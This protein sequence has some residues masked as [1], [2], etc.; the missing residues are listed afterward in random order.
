MGGTS[1][2]NATTSPSLES[3]TATTATSKTPGSVKIAFSMVTEAMFSPPG[4][5]GRRWCQ[6]AEWEGAKKGKRTHLG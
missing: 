5:D 2:T 3:G 6:L 1:R 4:T